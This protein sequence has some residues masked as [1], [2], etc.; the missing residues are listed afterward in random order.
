[1][2]RL[3]MYTNPFSS[4]NLYSGTHTYAQTTAIA[5]SINGT[6]RY[7]SPMKMPIGQNTE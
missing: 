7:I 3:D 1:M 6:N 2:K 4:S 5:G